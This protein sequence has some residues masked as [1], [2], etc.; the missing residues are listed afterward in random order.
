M[1]IPHR[2]ERGVGLVGVSCLAGD[3][4]EAL[5][6]HGGALVRPAEQGLRL[7]GRT[8]QD[9]VEPHLRLGKSATKPDE[10]RNPSDQA[11][12]ER[13]VVLEREA[14]RGAD[15]VV[16]RRHSFDPALLVG[17]VAQVGIGALRERREEIRVLPPQG[18]G[19]AGRFELGCRELA[20]RLQHPV[21]IA[22]RRLAV[23]DEALVDQRLQRVG[24]RRAHGL[25]RFVRAA[26]HEHRKP[27]E[28]LPLFPSEEVVRPA[29][30]RVQGLLARVDVAPAPELDAVPEPF[31]QLLRREDRDACGR[32]LEREREV[33]EARAELH[34]R[35]RLRE[36]RP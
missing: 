35:R 23:A 34:D 27:S 32:E 3:V 20:D 13:E 4:A 28:Q 22:S 10:E 8:R 21:P 24:V 16:V 5:G 11:Q 25:G 18:V 2:D 17:A 36:R 19:L 31:E 14:H 1:L 15:I 26:A 6:D 29:D 12:R 9:R 33:V 30:R 7:P